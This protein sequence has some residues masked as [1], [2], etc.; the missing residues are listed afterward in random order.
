MKN[1]IMNPKT[2]REVSIYGKIGKRILHQYG[3]AASHH[4]CFLDTNTNRCRKPKNKHEFDDPI[5]CA[6]R[7]TTKRCYRLKSGAQLARG[8]APAPFHAE[9]N[10]LESKPKIVVL[11][12]QYDHNDAFDIDG[13]EG[14][15]TI[16][17]Q[18]RDYDLI[19]K[20]ITS[21]KDIED[22]FSS[23][24]MSKIAHVV[25][26]CHGEEDRLIINYDLEIVIHSPEFYRLAELLREYLNPDASILLH[27]CCVG[28]GGPENDNFA[29]NLANVVPGHVVFGSENAIE[30]G[31]LLVTLADTKENKRL[32]MN[33]EIDPKA[34]YTLHKFVDMSIQFSGGGMS[35]KLILVVRV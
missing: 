24:Q 23:L 17:R 10:V 3:G 13:D 33:Y 14:L 9:E 20:Q 34:G 2:G 19:H 5:H 29:Q 28:T 16:F 26:M 12:S 6:Y 4:P 22:V 30:R 18:L 35:N 11:Q 21:M 8:R 32:E 27:S 25:I 1:T 31:D 15:F 7:R